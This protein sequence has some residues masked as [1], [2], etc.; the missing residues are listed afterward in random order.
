MLI[1]EIL[2]RN[3]R[4]YGD[5]IALVERDPAKNSRKEIT[6]EEFD[7]EANRVANA[8]LS[9]GIQKGDKVV[10]LMMNSIEWLPAYFGVLRTGAWVVPLN[11]RFSA[12]DIQYCSEIAEAKAFIFG[13][14]F[15]DRVNPIKKTLDKTVA[16]Y[17]FVGSDELRRPWIK[18]S[19]TT[20]LSAPMN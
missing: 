16:D 19:P 8:L 13:E 1:T 10:H 14:E 20:Y 3:A 4:M 9:R 7:A 5:E 11:F 17:I 6:W 18:P 12:D 2:A 15:I